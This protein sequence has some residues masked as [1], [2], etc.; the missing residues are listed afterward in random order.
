MR[1]LDGITDSTD[2]SLGELWELVMDREAWRV[3]IHGVEKG[4]TRLSDWTEL[5]WTLAYNII[6]ECFICATL[7]TV[8][9]VLCAQSLS[10]VQLFMAPWT[11]PGSFVTLQ[12]ILSMEFFWQE[13]WSGLPFPTPGDL[14]IPWP[15]E[16]SCISCIGK[17]ILY[18]L[19]RLGFHLF[20]KS[21]SFYAWQNPS[22][23]SKAHFPFMFNFHPPPFPDVNPQV[24]WM[25]SG[26]CLNTPCLPGI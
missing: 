16:G 8:W 11:C 1:W 10:P 5:N 9:L 6:Y 4:W 3:A 24:S 21:R 22:I 26:N 7:Y 12:A 18:H 13:Y 23:G 17:Q 25:H 14:T 19:C 15:R 2:V 20:L